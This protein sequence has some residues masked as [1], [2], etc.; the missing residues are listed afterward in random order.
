M[1]DKKF[2]TKNNISNPITKLLYELVEIKTIPVIVT[3]KIYIV[4]RI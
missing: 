2:I 1:I 4:S 3:P